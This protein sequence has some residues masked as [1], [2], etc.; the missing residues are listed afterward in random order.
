MATSVKRVGPA[1]LRV[2]PVGGRGGTFDD[3]CSI[4]RKLG[5]DEALVPAALQVTCSAGRGHRLP[6]RAPGRSRPQ[7]VLHHRAARPRPQQTAARPP[8]IELRAAVDRR[9]RSSLADQVKAASPR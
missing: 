9:S 7:L 2:G 3:Y 6:G 4:A 5:I 1:L 8:I